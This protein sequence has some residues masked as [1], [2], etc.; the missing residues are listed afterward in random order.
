LDSYSAFVTHVTSC[1]SSSD[2]SWVEVEG[3]YFACLQ[4]R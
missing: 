1:S 2:Y 4:R 3:R